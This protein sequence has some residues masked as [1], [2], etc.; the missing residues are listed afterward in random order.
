MPLIERRFMMGKAR[1][2]VFVV[3]MAAFGE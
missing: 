2:T 1:L 3:L